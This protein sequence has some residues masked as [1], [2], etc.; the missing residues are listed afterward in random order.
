MYPS[1]SH[2]SIQLSLY[3]YGVKCLFC[4]A[5]FIIMLI[6]NEQTAR[7]FSSKMV[8]FGIGRE[9]QFGVCNHGEPRARP[10][11][12]RVGECLYR[13]EEEIGKT[14]V[15]TESMAFQWLSHCQE[16]KVFLLPHGF[17]YSCRTWELPLLVSWLLSWGFCLLIFYNK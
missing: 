6:W 16:R 3:Q 12:A 17:C 13:E 9:L 2:L 4:A 15:K 8:L 14:I 5:F 7:F 11:M 1:I 10:H